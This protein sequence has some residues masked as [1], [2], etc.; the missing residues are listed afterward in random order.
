[1]MIEVL[2]T[3]FYIVVCVA[4]FSLA[5]IVHEAGHLI[6]ALKFGLKV[7]AFSVGFGPVLYKKTFKGVEYRL[8]AIPLGGYVSIPDVDPEGT[9]ALES[10]QVKVEGQGEGVKLAKKE[11]PAYQ[12]LVVALAGPM[13]NV[14]F[15]VVL[16]VAL[17]LIPSARF[18]VVSTEIGRVIEDGPAAKAGIMAGDIITSIGGHSVKSWTDLQTEVQIV[19]AKETEVELKRG[20]ETLKVKLTPE[21]DE[22]S[23]AALLMAYSTP[24]E[25]RAAAWMPYRNPI[26]QLKWDAGSIF[27]VLK[28]LT[29]PKEAKSTGKALGGPVMIATVLYSQVRRDFCD[30]LG[31]MRYLNVNLAILNLLPI[32]VLDG[33]LILFALFALIFRRRV[34]DFIVKYLSL[35]FMVVLLGLMAILILRDSVR[36]YT[37]HTRVENTSAVSQP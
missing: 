5:V 11:I 37:I 17:A 15:A 26:E 22:V 36:F 21:I 6:A 23:G 34:P 12:E 31:F 7:E 24:N 9:R 1:M 25:T 13:M 29:T 32:P 18:G 8:S 4:L 28:G 19:G 30:G 10:S 14:V 2:V 33:G 3:V 27:R 20:E 35:F 16:A